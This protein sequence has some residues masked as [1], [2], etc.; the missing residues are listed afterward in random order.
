MWSILIC[1][2]G[3]TGIHT[4]LKNQC[5]S[6]IDGFNSLRSHKDKIVKISLFA[7]TV[8]QIEGLESVLQ[9]VSLRQ[10]RHA[11]NVLV[12]GQFI[13]KSL[14]NK[15]AKRAIKILGSSSTGRTLAS[16]AKC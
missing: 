15:F 9:Y 13:S 4:G 2:C 7:P 10:Y 3:G 14:K 11:L 12:E 5:P 16:G 8:Q 6:G 1:D